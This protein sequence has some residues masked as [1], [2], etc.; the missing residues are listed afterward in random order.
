[1]VHEGS[2]K[3]SSGQRAVVSSDLMYTD[4]YI[5]PLAVLDHFLKQHRINAR[6]I[7]IYLPHRISQRTLYFVKA[8]GWGFRPVPFIP[9][10]RGGK[11]VH[12]TLVDQYNKLNIW[13]FG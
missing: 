10:P 5:F 2:G 9:P 13:T 8:A 3:I 1:M 4:S 6:K 11:G 12:R 7:L